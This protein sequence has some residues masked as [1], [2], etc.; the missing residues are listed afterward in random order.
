M[1]VSDRIIP[2][3][4]AG[5]HV[6][7]VLVEPARI[8]ITARAATPGAVCPTCGTVTGRVHSRYWRRLADLPWQDRQVWWH[9]QVRRF[10]CARCE[11]RIFAERLPGIAV[12]K[13]RRTTR[14]ADAQTCIGLA[15]G[16]E[17]GARLA[18]K[19]AMPVSGDTVLRLIRGLPLPPHPAPRV[20]GVDDWAWRRGQRYGTI[21]CDLERRRVIDLLPDRSAAPLRAWLMQHPTVTLISRDRSGPYA[22]AARRGAPDA[23]Q[24]ADRWHLL[25]NGSDALRGVL[26]RHQAKLREAA[27]ICATR[28]KVPAAGPAP[29]KQ[30][31]SVS[32]V[33]GGRQQARFEAVARLHK[34]GVA[35][36][37][38]VRRTGVARNAV[39]RWLRVGEAVPY[40]RAPG[41]SLL[42]RHLAFLEERWRAGHR[43]SA[44][45]WRDLHERG[46]EGGYDIVRRWAKR[47]RGMEMLQ[48]DVPLPSWRVPSSR[49]AT[50][51]L[52]SDP[53]ELND[54][55]RVFVDTLR[56]IAPEIR[57]AADLINGLGRLL[58]AGNANAFEAW[59]GAAST[60]ALCRFAEGLRAD[61]QAVR[62]AITLPWSNGPVEGQINRLKLIKR[63]M[64]GRAK[65]DLLRRRILCAV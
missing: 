20:I 44:E 17:P 39:R 25:V 38:I 43:N 54:A 19:L 22:E 4:P 65:F 27:R 64:F 23:V 32:T 1:Q 61:Y 26:D 40:R 7:A 29:L 5:L 52:T 3:V 37:Q 47:R 42:D 48:P 46:F 35:I 28:E 21:V 34:Q 55:D 51:L 63:Q 49:S 62:A 31:R 16:G 59:L 13:G 24:V 60:T 12:R 8:L 45:L 57:A 33:Q 11:R 36:R 14:L 30:P 9:L 56:A 18:C 15:L 41:P 50:R 58:R 53:A 10:R 2:T 6:E